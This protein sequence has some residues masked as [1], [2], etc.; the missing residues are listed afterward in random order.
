[1][2]IADDKI[3]S[4]PNNFIF[5]LLVLLIFCPQLYWVDDKTLAHIYSMDRYW[6]KN[7]VSRELRLCANPLGFECCYKRL[8]LPSGWC[9]LFSLNNPL[10]HLAIHRDADLE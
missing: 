4:I 10:R 6:N 7:G 5:S 8:E 3:I 1:M 9:G 2:E